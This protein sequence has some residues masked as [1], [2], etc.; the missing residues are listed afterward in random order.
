MVLPNLKF[1]INDNNNWGIKE[2]YN[3]QDLQ[4]LKD[5]IIRFISAD[6]W[7]CKLNEEVLFDSY[8]YYE[9]Y[10]R[11]PNFEETKRKEILDNPEIF[12]QDIIK[13]KNDSKIIIYMFGSYHWG[14][15]IDYK[16]KEDIFYM[17]IGYESENTRDCILKLKKI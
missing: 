15:K 8:D 17:T 11:L 10:G 2:K 1:F 3:T 5:V 12:I 14:I 7:G 13:N 4:K 16:Y 9:K 6:C